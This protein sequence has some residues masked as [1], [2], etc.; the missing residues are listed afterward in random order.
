MSDRTLHIFS[1]FIVG[2]LIITVILLIVLKLCDITGSFSFLDAAESPFFSSIFVDN[3]SIVP[4]NLGVVWADTIVDFVGI[5]C[6][7]SDNFLAIAMSVVDDPSVTS[8]P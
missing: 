2:F 8:I 7:L 5:C 3:F 6:I 4:E 1:V